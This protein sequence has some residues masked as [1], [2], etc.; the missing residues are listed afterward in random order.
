MCHAGATGNGAMAGAVRDRHGRSAIDG[1]VLDCA[2]RHT[3]GTR[4]PGVCGECTSDEESAGAQDGYPG[5]SMAVEVAYLRAAEKFVPARGRDSGNANVL[6]T[7]TAAHWGCIA[8]Y[9]THAKSAD[10]NERAIGQHDQR[11][12]WSHRPGDPGGDRGRREGSMEIGQIPRP[13]SESQ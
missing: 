1:G 13:A 6:A 4:N 11:Y 8:L 3:V 10:A 12:Q 5:M 2:V 7:E 9:S